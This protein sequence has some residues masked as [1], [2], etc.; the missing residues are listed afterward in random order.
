[1][2]EKHLL[3]HTARAMKVRPDF[4]GTRL[5]VFR[6][7]YSYSL[8]RAAWPVAAAP[9]CGNIQTTTAIRAMRA[10]LMARFDPNP[11]PAPPSA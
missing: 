6:G 9:R 1:M 10:T 11:T 7:V 5:A 3:F 8:E 4:I 2:Y